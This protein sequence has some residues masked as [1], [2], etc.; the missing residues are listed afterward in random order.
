MIFK[1]THVMLKEKLFWGLLMLVLLALAFWL[2]SNN[3]GYVL[4]I[5]SPYRVQFSFNFFLFLMAIAFITL[6]Y[7]LGFIRYLRFFPSYW[8][9]NKA[10]KNLA[11]SHTALI[12][13]VNA[14]LNE[15]I[16]SAEMAILRA[17]HLHH[18][19]NLDE[20]SALITKKKTNASN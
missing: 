6:H 11:E 7:F 9:K 14:L 17:N 5:R 15:D 12:E 10:H 16:T 18:N 19:E 2:L 13:S 3:Q 8:R 1:N 4:I 20:L